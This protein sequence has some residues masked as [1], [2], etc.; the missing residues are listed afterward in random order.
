MFNSAVHLM[1]INP[2]NRFLTKRPFPN[3]LFRLLWIYRHSRA[4]TLCCTNSSE[5]KFS[6]GPPTRSSGLLLQ[7]SLLDR[8]K[9]MTL[10][11]KH[12]QHDDD[13]AEERRERKEIVRSEGRL[14]D[15]D[16]CGEGDDVI[17]NL[18]MRDV[19]AQRLAHLGSL[20]I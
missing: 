10:R 6:R 11:L 18:T 17:R 8:F 20:S 16:W 4:D 13:G 14:G 1:R 3:T 2:L 12:E 7:V 15:Q 5:V 19:H 9:A